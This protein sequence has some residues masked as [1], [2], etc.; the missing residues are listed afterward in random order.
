MRVLTEHSGEIQ[1]VIQH[2]GL[3]PGST[4]LGQGL[5]AFRFNP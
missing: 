5:T 3:R 1:T 2:E 4:R